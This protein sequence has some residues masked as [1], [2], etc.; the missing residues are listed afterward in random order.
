MKI[1]SNIPSFC[2]QNT[3]QTLE[4]LLNGIKI[5]LKHLRIL[6]STIRPLQQMEH[7][8]KLHIYILY[9]NMILYF[10]MFD[11]FII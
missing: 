4:K 11:L 10:N 8:C 2:Q 9:Y 1:R 5:E 6:I 7:N 3:S